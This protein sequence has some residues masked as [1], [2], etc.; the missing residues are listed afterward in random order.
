MQVHGGVITGSDIAACPSRIGILIRFTSFLHTLHW[1]TG[2][3]DMG[4]LGVSFF[5][6]SY[7]F[8]QWAG[9]R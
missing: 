4:H 5:G 6:A 9:Q 7:F 3:V 2:S 1:P 8:E